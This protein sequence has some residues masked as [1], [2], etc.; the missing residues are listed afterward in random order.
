MPTVNL[1]YAKKRCDPVTE[2]IHSFPQV[3]FK[4]LYHWHRGE[5]MMSMHRIR[6]IKEKTDKLCEFLQKAVNEQHLR[7][8]GPRP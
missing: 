1:R 8:D 5:Y 7:G 4:F 3:L 2:E 6:E